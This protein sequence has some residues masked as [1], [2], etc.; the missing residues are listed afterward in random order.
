MSRQKATGNGKLNIKTKLSWANN[1][2]LLRTKELSYLFTDELNRP[3][4]P[5]KVSLCSPLLLRELSRVLDS[6]PE[7]F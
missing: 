7:A 6:H 4:V 1:S 5:W 3:E 2:E